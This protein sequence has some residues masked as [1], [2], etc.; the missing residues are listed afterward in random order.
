VDDRLGTRPAL[1]PPQAPIELVNPP[2][3]PPEGT[4]FA[5]A[6]WSNFFE[7]KGPP[8]ADNA[9]MTI[10]VSWRDVDDDWDVYLARGNTLIAVS[11]LGNTRG[12]KIVMRD[13]APGTNY[14]ILM[15]NYDQTDPPSED[16]KATVSFQGPTQDQEGVKESWTLSCFQPNGKLHSVEQVGVDR[17]ERADVGKTCQKDKK[18]K[19]TLL[20]RQP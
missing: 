19:G 1:A 10:D 16:W 5:N 15:L 9:L 3:T 12:E 17:G 18:G 20:H 2:G 11:G 13:P 8:E 7:V 6:E 4:G 14:R